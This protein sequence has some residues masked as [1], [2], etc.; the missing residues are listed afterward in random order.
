M[1]LNSE[2]PVPAPAEIKLE[3]KRILSSK[4]FARS[5]K[6]S[7]LLQVVID[8]TL[9]EGSISEGLLRTEIW[10]NTVIAP[11]LVRQTALDV[12]RRLRDFYVSDGTDSIVVIDLPVGPPYRA[13]FSFNPSSEY[14]DCLR[15]GFEFQKRC[16]FMSLKASAYYFMHAETAYNSQRLPEGVQY[17]GPSMEAGLGLVESLLLLEI[18]RLLLSLEESVDGSQ[19]TKR[20]LRILTTLHKWPLSDEFFVKFHVLSGALWL[21]QADWIVASSHFEAARE[22]NLTMAENSLWTALW[23]ATIRSVED[24]KRIIEAA[25]IKDPKGVG[26][27]LAE[28][29]FLYMSRDSDRSLK[30][31]RAAAAYANRD[32]DLA[33]LITG[34]A[35]LEIGDIHCSNAAYM[36]LRRI[37]TH[38][39]IDNYY[40]GGFKKFEVSRVSG[41]VAMAAKRLSPGESAQ[42]MLK[43]LYMTE[44]QYPEYAPKSGIKADA[45][46]RFE[47]YDDILWQPRHLQKAIAEIA[48]G[49]Y[50][51]ALIHIKRASRYP[52]A[53]WFWALPLLDP[54]RQFPE[55]DQ[56]VNARYRDFRESS[57]CPRN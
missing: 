43:T 44:F 39:I 17:G 23:Y 2:Q 31:S 53:N 13:D 51:R 55:F 37:S 50:G 29:Y 40:L 21:L 54:L 48:D 47:G 33:F 4:S 7:R 49:R 27:N 34:L 56:I 42:S 22:R 10:G 45:E 20:A 5:G 14:M 57:N 16:D 24:A 1:D 9:E 19:F 18:H 15:R 38:V 35:F 6:R 52:L 28:A 3:L 46:R 36:D 8:R 11:N 30:S 12:R 25:K 32:N 41:L 26:V